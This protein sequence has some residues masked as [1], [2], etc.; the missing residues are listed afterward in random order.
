[1]EMAFLAAGFFFS[2]AFLS[3]WESAF[4]AAGFTALEAFFLAE[5]F[6]AMAKVLGGC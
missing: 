2:V 3:G 4:L 6:V 1:L 5:V